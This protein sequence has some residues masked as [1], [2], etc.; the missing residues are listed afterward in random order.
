MAQHDIDLD[1]WRD[2]YDVASR[3]RALA[4]WT[5]MEEIDVFGVE[6]G[7]EADLIFVSVMGALGEHHAVAVYPGAAALTQLWALHNDEHA[8][9][10]QVLEIPQVQLSFENKKFLE[11]ED[12][13]TTKRLG[14]NL[15][16][17]NAWP[18][19]RSYRP[20][21]APWFIEKNDATML[22]VALE[23]LLH[24][25][26]R[27]QANPSAVR[28]DDPQTYLI[29]TLK[30][31]SNG[32]QWTDEFRHIPPVSI[33]IP[34]VIPDADALRQCHAFPKAKN[35]IEV[36]LFLVPTP[37]GDGKLRPL[38]PYSLLMV[39]STSGSIVNQEMLVVETS[40]NDVLCSIPTK[41]VDQLKESGV[42][43][44]WLT[45]RPGRLAD[46]LKPTCEALGIQLRIHRDLVQL[47]PARK[48][49]FEFLAR[50]PL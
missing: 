28:P 24:V 8:T 7:D 15:R 18:R 46:V 41:V 1:I 40:M 38:Y 43:P 48:S 42:R 32:D 17:K 19:F 11:P 49:L 25:A 44:A 4:P 36:D 30:R 10:E 33:S 14:L 20:G 34:R 27:L 37:I 39:E 9:S 23:Q 13:R 29:R 26:P 31:G 16:G 5:W 50:G 3:V 6:M 22:E 45:V 2:L 35:G 12:R 47:D 21:F